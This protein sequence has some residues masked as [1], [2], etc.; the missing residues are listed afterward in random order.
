MKTETLVV[1][2]NQRKLLKGL[3]IN[4]RQSQFRVRVL[5]A[6]SSCAHFDYSRGRFRRIIPHST[7]Q[8]IS[9]S[10]YAIILMEWRLLSF[11][12]T[13]NFSIIN[14]YVRLTTAIRCVANEITSLSP[15]RFRSC[16]SNKFIVTHHHKLF[17]FR[18]FTKSGFVLLF[19]L[20]NLYQFS[21]R[22][23]MTDSNSEREVERKQQIDALCVRQQ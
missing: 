4:R 13:H 8:H 3:R 14:F 6:S 18:L 22:S 21:V 17:S 1:Q 15:A 23:S 5:C 9:Q 10:S 19:S 2:Y 12:K 16:A 20:F 7:Q 11:I